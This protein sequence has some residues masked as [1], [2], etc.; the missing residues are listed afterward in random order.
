MN[1]NQTGKFIK[2]LR[3]SKCLSQNQLA[4]MIPISRQAIS[5]WERNE[6]IP[7][8]STLLRLSE[9]FDVTINELLLG[10]RIEKPSIE[11]LEKRALSIIDESNKKIYKNKIKFVYSIITIVLLVLLFFIYYFINSYNSIKVYTMNYD[12]QEFTLKD[13]LLILTNQKSYLRLGELVY[14]K[15]KINI[16]NLRLYYKT[17][18]KEILIAEDK[19]LDKMTLI[20]LYGYNDVFFARKIDNNIYLKIYYNDKEKDIKLII[21]RDFTNNFLLF[22]NYKNVSNEI[23]KEDKQINGNK[24]ISMVKEKGIR[25]NDTYTLIINYKE[26]QI[27][28]TY[29]IYSKELTLY[30]DNNEIVWNYN[31]QTKY[32]GCKNISDNNKCKKRIKED[33]NNYLLN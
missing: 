16:T 30:N 24:V 5:K 14:N 20:D 21:K 9:I 32:Y 28:I 13:G 26:S 19:D 4:D 29:M 1:Q 33:I 15:D 31:L 2:E 22:N 8:S 27:T 11:E 12:D 17:D 23:N 7:D 10:K 3:K 6:T 18:K 25:A